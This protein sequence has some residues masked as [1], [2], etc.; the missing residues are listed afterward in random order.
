MRI[1][2]GLLKEHPACLRES[3]PLG[4][5]PEME[6]PRLTQEVGTVRLPL[7]LQAYEL[8]MRLP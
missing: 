3:S 1:F 7:H 5:S 6:V 2:L 4:T 8:G